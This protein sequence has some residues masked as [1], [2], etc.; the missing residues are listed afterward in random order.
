VRLKSMQVRWLRKS[1]RSV[2]D[3]ATDIPT[4]AAATARLAVKRVL[5]SD[6]PFART[7]AAQR[8]S[9]TGSAQES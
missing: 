1:L 4:G 6:R 2:D 7:P 5:D 9:S 3:E 8:T